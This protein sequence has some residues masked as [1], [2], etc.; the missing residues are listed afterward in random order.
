MHTGQLVA[1]LEAEGAALAEAAGRGEWDAPVPHL[2]WTLEE[3]V[4]HT[5]GVHR[6]SDDVLRGRAASLD[7]SGELTDS[8][9]DAGALL[10]WFGDGVDALLETLRTA[11]P[12]LQ[13]PTLMR[14]DSPLHFWARRQVHETGVH[15]ADAQAAAG[16]ATPFDPDLAQDGIAEL[17][18]GFARGR[19]FAVAT[20]GTLALA[21][22]DG[23]S[24]LVTFGGERNDCRES[25]DLTETD[26][27]VRGS[28][29][30]LYRWVWNRPSEATV[31]GDHDVAGR[32]GGTVR[33]RRG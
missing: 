31:E 1:H 9:P 8:G 13:V 19:P 33:I 18:T 11:D 25:A 3:L 24:W 26:V 12:D 2:G 4:R 14:A 22:S 29:S 28:S 10:D 32:W 30:D 17:L 15:R 6:W 16:T 20:P 5:G 23:P 21:A 27:T 7:T